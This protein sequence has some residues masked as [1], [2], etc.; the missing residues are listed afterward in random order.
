MVDDWNALPDVVILAA[1]V[2]AFKRNLDQHMR[3]LNR[4]ASDLENLEK[5]WNLADLE[6]TWKKPGI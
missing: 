1:G 6:K 4:V 2:N 5:A 3:D